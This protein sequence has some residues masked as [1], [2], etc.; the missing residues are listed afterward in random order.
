MIY[1]YFQYSSN[2]KLTIAEIN[3][4]NIDDL[5][6]SFVDHKE[7]TSKQFQHVNAGINEILN[8]LP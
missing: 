2:K 5:S 1:V 7:E 3:K 6:Q 4:I 8:K